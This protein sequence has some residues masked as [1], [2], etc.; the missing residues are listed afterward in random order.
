[1]NLKDK[2][3]TTNNKQQTRKKERKEGSF[4]SFKR[5]DDDDLPVFLIIFLTL[6]LSRYSCLSHFKLPADTTGDT[7]TFPLRK[8]HLMIARNTKKIYFRF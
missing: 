2:M 1:M 4:K 5:D 8:V 3:K 7:L 6:S